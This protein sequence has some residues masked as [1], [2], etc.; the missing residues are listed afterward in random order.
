MKLPISLLLACTLTGFS[1]AQDA[2]TDDQ[3]PTAEESTAAKE[4]LDA[5]DVAVLR[6]HNGQECTVRGEIIRTKDWDGGPQ[7][8][9][10]M[11]FLDFKGGHFTA[12]TFEDD[13]PNFKEGLPAQIYGKKTIELTGKIEERNG[14][15]QIKLT[16]PAQVKIVEGTGKE[17]KKDKADDKKDDKKERRAKKES[18]KSGDDR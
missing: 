7:K 1:L 12:V 8:K 9:K 11:N 10:K 17:A 6:A 4:A 5:S 2:K 14:N 15:Y 18:K 3:K 16:D 13:Y